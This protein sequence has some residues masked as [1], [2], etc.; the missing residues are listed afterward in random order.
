MLIISHITAPH[1]LV[2]ENII[3]ISPLSSDWLRMPDLKHP[4]MDAPTAIRSLSLRMNLIFQVGLSM[5]IGMIVYFAMLIAFRVPGAVKY[6]NKLLI[7]LR[8]RK[9]ESEL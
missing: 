6:V 8:L 1:V 2:G 4:I 3:K 5:F 7:K 9:S